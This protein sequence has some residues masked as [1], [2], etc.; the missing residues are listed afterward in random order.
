MKSLVAVI[1]TD[2]QSILFKHFENS[3]TQLGECRGNYRLKLTE[4]LEDRREWKLPQHF[5]I[6]DIFR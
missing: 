2:N 1:D 5:T 6:D 3:V 4:F